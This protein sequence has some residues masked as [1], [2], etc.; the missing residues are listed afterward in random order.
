[1][2]IRLDKIGDERFTWRESLELETSELGN[3]DLRRLEPVQCEGSIDSTPSGFVLRMQLS[4]RQHLG[5]VRCL[6]D[7]EQELE[8]E[9]DLLV[10]VADDDDPQASAE[11]EELG[12]DD[13]GVL[14][15][16]SPRLDTSTLVVEQVVLGLPMKP[17]CREDC[18]GLCGQ[19]GADL[20]EGP[21]D[22]NP[23]VDPR[24]AAL[25]NLASQTPS[26]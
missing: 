2:E 7:L 6:K 3:G 15:L 24:W 17:L 19:C 5:C 12:E 1:M 10:G 13:L 18:A 8:A 9:I 11:L 14:I 25:A 22:C 20:G 23:Q 4:Y 16:D 21:C 26:E